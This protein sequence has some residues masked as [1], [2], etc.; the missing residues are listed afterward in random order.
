MADKNVKEAKAAEKKKKSD[1]PGFFA[2]LG[3]Y[4]R[5]IKGEWK[6]VVWPSKKTIMNNTV[7]VLV[8]VL[9]TAIVVWGLD[10][11]FAG[12]RTLLINLL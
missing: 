9:I 5:D 10:A 4:F 11:I 7:V 12:L 1:K 6:R 8:L 3:K 2:R